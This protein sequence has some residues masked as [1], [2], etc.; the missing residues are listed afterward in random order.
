M[1]GENYVLRLSGSTLSLDTKFK[2][3][4]DVKEIYDFKLQN[5]EHRIG[6]G[7]S[8][9]NNPYPFMALVKKDDYLQLISASYDFSSTI[10]QQKIANNKK[11]LEIKQ[12]TQAYFNNF[13]FN[14]SFFFFTYND[15]SDFTSGYS[16]N[17]VVNEDH[18]NYTNIGSVTFATN[19][20]SPFDF[21]DEVEIKELNIMYNNNFV[22]YK[23]L[24]KV[25]QITYHG[26]VDLYTNKIVWNTD[27]EVL[28]FIPYI[29]DRYT[30]NQGEYEYADSM[31]VITKDSAYRVCAINYD[32]DCVYKCP[33]NTKIVYDTD[34][35][36]CVSTSE[37]VSC[38]GQK[39]TLLPD[40]ICIPKE[41]CNTTIYKM[42]DNYCGLCKY[43]ESP[44]NCRFIGSDN[45]LDESI[46][47]EEGV[48]YYNDKSCL[49]ECDKGYILQ[50]DIC[51]PHCYSTCSR[52]NDYSTDKDNQ[53]CKSCID[54]Y[55]LV[56]NTN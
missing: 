23:I 17:S 52:C 10:T 38:S 28:L 20:D 26:I 29:R 1:N 4:S 56:D 14:N 9:V 50:N 43:M 44:K 21:I 2:F 16:I 49:L 6:K 31:L 37:T 42:N 48:I 12:Y 8:W 47:L 22:Y 19:L 53:Q 36:K 40:N 30:S 11:L 45:C 13:H 15:L 25:T 24:D 51:V 3:G 33:D 27:K 35:T 7:E 39:R 46:L 18:V 55:Y 41:Q 5:R 32:G 34:G 54:G